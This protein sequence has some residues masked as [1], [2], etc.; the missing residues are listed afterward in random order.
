MGFWNK[1]FG[2]NEN[3]DE[4]KTDKIN[5]VAKKQKLILYSMDNPQKGKVKQVIFG[6]YPQEA[7]IE[8]EFLNNILKSGQLVE[9]DTYSFDDSKYLVCEIR[10]GTE[11]TIGNHHFRY[12]SVL[13]NGGLYKYMFKFAPIIWNIYDLGSRYLLVSSFIID[14]TSFSK[15]EI[16]NYSESWLRKYLNND[17]VNLAFSREQLTYILPTRVKNNYFECAGYGKSNDIFMPD[18]TDKVFILSYANLFGAY[19]DQLS[20]PNFDGCYLSQ[21]YKF[22]SERAFTSLIT[23]FAAIKGGFTKPMQRYSS[24]WLRGPI[25]ERWAKYI[26]EDGQD[27]SDVILGRCTRGIRPCICL[28]KSTVQIEY[29]NELSGDAL[30]DSMYLFASIKNGIKEIPTIEEALKE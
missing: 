1:L 21:E 4:I 25:K 13:D 12:R 2:N 6:S 30:C 3:I 22:G 11:L 8:K 28:D 7:V 19:G 23:D 14:A 5:D 17:F 9:K 15:G 29:S 26:D 10:G 27:K 18:T 24:Y 20:R 16:Q